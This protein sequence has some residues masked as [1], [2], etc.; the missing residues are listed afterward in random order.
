M[1]DGKNRS[2]VTNPITA[3][4]INIM[5]TTIATKDIVTPIVAVA[6]VPA[7]VLVVAA[8]VPLIVAPVAA[9]PVPTV[10]APAVVAAFV[11]PEVAFFKSFPLFINSLA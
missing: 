2:A 11:A 7:T 5:A 1:K 8:P 6:P 9:A 4:T 3:I 10:D